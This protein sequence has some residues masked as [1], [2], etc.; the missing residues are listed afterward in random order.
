MF[1]AKNN[2]K[3]TIKGTSALEFASTD[4]PVILSCLHVFHPIFVRLMDGEQDV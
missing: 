4:E 3:A 2:V 1:L